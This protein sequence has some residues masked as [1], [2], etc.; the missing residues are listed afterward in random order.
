VPGVAVSGATVQDIVLVSNSA[1]KLNLTIVDAVGAALGGACVTLNNATKCADNDGK[2]SFDLAGG[3]Y[4]ASMCRSQ[5]TAGT[6]PQYAQTYWQANG[7]SFSVSSDT[8]KTIQ[9]PVHSI[10]V[11][12]KDSSGNTIANSTLSTKGYSGPAFTSDGVT[13]TSSYNNYGYA[14]V[15][16]GN[17]ATHRL[18]QTYA[19]QN[20]TIAATPPSNV[21]GGIGTATQAVTA[22]GS[23]VITCASTVTMA[24]IITDDTGT[25][26]P[27]HCVQLQAGPVNKQSCS[28]SD[29]KYSLAMAPGSYTLIITASIYKVAP[30][31]KYEQHY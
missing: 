20:A 15:G 12:V 27:N 25:V 21:T 4:S 28:G 19:G 1:C 31:G 16:A 6:S 3:T 13:F 23:I 10:T 9:V 30:G 22:S 24:G 2:V 18:L 7:G 29:G 8:N 17:S 11:S 5:Y 14:N 26:L